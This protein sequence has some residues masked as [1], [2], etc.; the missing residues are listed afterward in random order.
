[1]RW[2]EQNW[3]YFA[4]PTV[5]IAA[6]VTVIYGAQQ[7]I[8]S[9]ISRALDDPGTLKRIAAA[10]KPEMIIDTSGSVL[11]DMGAY[12]YI[13]DMQV[14]GLTLTKSNCTSS[15]TITPKHYMASPPLI[16]GIDAPWLGVA[17]HRGKG[18]DWVFDLD[19]GSYR[20]EGPNR[21][22]MEI[23]DK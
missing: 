9:R 13:S 4:G 3:K 21:L 20:D 11:A 7:Y 19:W 6:V 15:I 17:A 14:T 23:I 22:R 2:I 8:D 5:G 1:M 18:L 16:T 10:A 12:Q